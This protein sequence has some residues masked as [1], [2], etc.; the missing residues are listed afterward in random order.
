MRRYDPWVS[1]LEI[2]RILTVVIATI[3]RLPLTN[4]DFAIANLQKRYANL[5][6]MGT[7][8]PDPNA[9]QT[10]EGFNVDEV[11]K[12]L[13]AEFFQEQHNTAESN[14][15][16]TENSRKENNP[17]DHQ[18]LQTQTEDQTEPPKPSEPSSQTDQPPPDSNPEAKPQNQI[19][20]SALALA[21]LGWDN[22]NNAPTDTTT[23]TTT[24][25]LISCAACFRR[26][27]L[28][29]YK[30]RENGT[31]S[32]Y[33]TLDAANE[34][35]E[36]CPWISREAQSGTGTAKPAGEK[37][38]DLR[39]GWELLVLA[40]RALYRR[41]VRSMAAVAS[42]DGVGDGV[43]GRSAS[44]SVSAS[45]SCVGGDGSPGGT[46]TGDDHNEGERP[47]PVVVDE[48]TKKF[49]DREWWARIRRMKQVLNVRAPRGRKG[50][51]SR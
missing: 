10:P 13:P 27:G 37:M 48:E 45:Q 34:H 11:A 7:Q 25:D 14:S 31:K 46:G 9:I 28:W 26:L 47:G 22:T 43:R 50:D 21:S 39:S 51:G 3:H 33:G 20:K 19:N 23:K 16:Q 2:I 36:Y 49:T 41:R 38:E 30:P 40:G 6:A 44:V 12:M 1:V 8:L 17:E 24:T 4:P 18:Q 42:V 32:V 5:A 15:H 35:M 29:L